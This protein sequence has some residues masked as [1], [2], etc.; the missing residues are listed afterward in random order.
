MVCHLKFPESI[1]NDPGNDQPGIPLVIGRNDVPWRLVSARGAETFFIGRDILFP[2]R[3][4]VYVGRAEFPIFV[5]FVDPLEESLSLLFPR[6]MKEDL[7]N[8]GAVVEQVPFQIHD[9]TIA[10]CPERFVVT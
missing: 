7:D 8:V 3:P 9:G 5:R 10:I 6:K 2:E 4:L 1:D